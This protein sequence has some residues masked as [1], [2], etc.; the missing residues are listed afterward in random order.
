[1]A[2]RLLTPVTLPLARSG[3]SLPRASFSVTFSMGKGWKNAGSASASPGP[4]PAVRGTQHTHP[5]ENSSLPG[6]S[7]SAAGSFPRPGGSWVPRRGRPSATDNP[8]RGDG[9]RISTSCTR[10]AA[11]QVTSRA[12]SNNADWTKSALSSPQRDLRTLPQKGLAD[13]ISCHTSIHFN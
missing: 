6:G 8:G 9:L 4:V 2:I 5:V 11:G 12:E 3:S 13:P 7:P 1:M 10:K